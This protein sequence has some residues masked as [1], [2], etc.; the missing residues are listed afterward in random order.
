MKTQKHLLLAFAMLAALYTGIATAGELVLPS[1]AVERNAMVQVVYRMPSTVTGKGSL[2]IHWSDSLGRVVEDRTQAIDLLD[3][4]E[5]RFPLDLRRAV[6]MKN[7]LRVHLSIDGKNRK[8][9]TDRREED[10]QVHFVARPPGGEWR[11]YAIIMWQPYPAKLLAA[12]KTLGINGGQ[13]NGR[14]ESPPDSL[15]D[16]NLR[17]YSENIGTDFYSE[18]HRWRPDRIQHWSF[19]QAKELYKRDPAGKEAFKRHPSFSDPVWI[20]R[21]HDRLVESAKRNSPYRPF[22]YSLGDETGIADLAAFWDFDFSD[23]SLAGMR[24]WLRTKYASLPDLNREWGSDFTSWDLVT[25]M[26]THEAMQRKDDNFASWAD[27]KEWM[28]VSFAGA[29]QMGSDAIHQV[30]KEAYVSIGGG[31]MPGWGGY[32]YSRLTKVLS[33]IEPYDI[34]NN[35][36]IIRSLNPRMPMLTTGFANGNWE[37][38]RV[39]SELL[40]GNRGLILWDE[41][42]E[43]VD[44]NGKPGPRGLEASAYYNELR[45]GIAA[46]IINGQRVTDPIAIHYSQPSMRTEWM[47]ARRPHGDDWAER[48]ARV[49]R[50]DNDFMRLRESWC[51]LVEDQ[52]MQYNFVSYGQVE[53]GGLL[54]R[55][56]RILVLPRSSALSE[57][58][59]GAIREFIAQGGAVIADGEPG[60]FN[61]H[62]R[63]LSKSSL[64]DLFGG[65]H[66][67]PVTERAFGKGKAIFLKT[68]TLE[69]HQ[70]RL[71]K[72]EGPVHTLVGGLL[73]SNGNAPEFKVADA[74]G[75]P[76]VG[77]E[78]HVFRNG[79]VRL[80]ALLSNPQM[81][82][83]EL[84]PPD[85]RSNERFETPVTVTLTLPELSHVYN[86]RQAKAL[87]QKKTIQVTLNPYEPTIFAVAASPLPSLRIA[88]PPQAE[89][90]ASVNIGIGCV[91]T[92]AATHVLHV[93]VVDPQGRLIL[94]YSENIFARHGQAVK[95]LPIAFNDPVGKWTIRIHDILSGQTETV[96]LVV[97]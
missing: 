5:V 83:D 26:T 20:A 40:H 2:R 11:D 37:R 71:V 66:D 79:G 8:G 29:L 60:V 62:S 22:F 3:E 27:F 12:L 95:L 30:D 76:V 41:K 97:K 88:V 67:Q 19:L 92:P 13:Y 73:R 78:T 7:E 25:P 28:D 63:R 68:A 54:K 32:D 43:Y 36:E 90:G 52:G 82:V 1:A 96:P 16:N 44:E 6:A 21:I 56:Y 58:E 69:Y 55:G 39:W 45:G 72:K 51:R 61:D 31:Q 48:L 57:A 81:R 84:G 94:P 85:F 34:G 80:V 42:H 65:P 46:L 35:I 86:V 10:A 33:A 77:V 59:S 38:Q 93:E 17:W 4:L 50:T 23:Q 14:L 87:G 24:L 89:R 49:E 15:I 64:S 74:A 9:E 91:R 70:N 53:Q 75:N 47:L 18:Y